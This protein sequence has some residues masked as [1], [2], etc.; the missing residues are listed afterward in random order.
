MNVNN[1]GLNSKR[2]NTLVDVFRIPPPANL[3]W[4]KVAALLK[5]LGFSMQQSRG[6]SV[7]FEIDDIVF[8]THRP[9]GRNELLRAQVKK[10][11]I[12]L[13][14]IGITP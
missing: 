5:G 13:E 6:S 3:S 8:V 9:H 12:F 11:R 7:S 4:R 2:Y 14:G 1:S 10:L